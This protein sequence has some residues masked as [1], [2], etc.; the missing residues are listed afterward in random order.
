MSLASRTVHASRPVQQ[1]FIAEGMVGDDASTEDLL[2]LWAKRVADRDAAGA[3]ILAARD[4]HPC[5]SHRQ[6]T[7][8]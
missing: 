8:D 7:L 4:G 5:M 6:S 2:A 1:A 3:A